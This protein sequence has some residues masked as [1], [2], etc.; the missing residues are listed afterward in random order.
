MR[1]RVGLGEDVV[2]HRPG[3]VVAALVGRL[4]HGVEAA[5]AAEVA[6]LMDRDQIGLAVEPLPGAIGALVVDHD[7]LVDRAVLGA[8]R[9]R[10]SA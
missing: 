10:C 1:E 7:D 6:G 8:D 2:V 5:G 4:E 3:E 9:R